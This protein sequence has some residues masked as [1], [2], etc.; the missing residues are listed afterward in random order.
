M[1]DSYPPV[2]TAAVFLLACV[3]SLPLFFEIYR[4]AAFNTVPSDGYER[5]V[6]YFTSGKGSWPGAPFGYRAL[7]VLA[8]VPFYWILPLY[9]FTLSHGDPSTLRALQALAFLSFVAI[10]ATATVAYIAVRRT[11][12]GSASEAAFAASFS[13]VLSGF[14][15]RGADIDA[16]AIFLIFLLLYWLERPTLFCPVF[17]ITPFVNEKILGFFVFLCIARSI[18]VPGFWTSYRW[19]IGSVAIAVFMYALMVKI[20]HLPGNDYQTSIA[21]LL[22][23][24]VSTLAITFSAKGIFMNLVFTLVVL[25]PCLL[26]FLDRCPANSLITAYDFLVPI[27]MFMTGLATRVEFDVGRIVT[28]A[29]P[30][31]VLATTVLISRSDQPMIERH[32]A[33]TGGVAPTLQLHFFGEHQPAGFK[34]LLQLAE[35]SSGRASY[36]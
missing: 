8:A 15:G 20:V 30:L 33:L 19:Q 14:C 17:L 28:H 11:L 29:L 22:P 25:V 34:R 12:R 36:S 27:G 35:H 6:L 26:L 5:F 18:F 10:A 21:E 16:L 1:K 2:N 3:V 7:S 9:R 31:A 32:P 13:I 24:V 23:S 4:I